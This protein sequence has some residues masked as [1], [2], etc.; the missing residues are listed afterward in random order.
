MTILEDLTDSWKKFRFLKIWSESTLMYLVFMCILDPLLF[1][2]VCLHN[3]ENLQNWYKSRNRGWWRM[4]EFQLLTSMKHLNDKMYPSQKNQRRNIFWWW[5]YSWRST[6]EV[7]WKRRLTKERVM[8]ILLSH[9]L[10]ANCSS[11]C[12]WY[13]LDKKKEPKIGRSRNEVSSY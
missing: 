9:S 13:L 7:A 1:I 11:R 12:W 5:K 8:R 2:I 10:S 6:W 4:K 3:S